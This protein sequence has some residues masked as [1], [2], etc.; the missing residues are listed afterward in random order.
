LHTKIIISIAGTSAKDLITCI[1]KISTEFSPTAFELNLSCPNV[2]HNKNNSKLI[3]Q[4]PKQTAKIIKKIKKSTKNKIIAKLSPAVTDITE[5]ALAAEQAGADAVS[6]VNTYPGMAVNYKTGKPILGNISGG[7]S[8]PA[9]KPLA[10]KAVYDTAKKINIP[11]IGIGGISSATDVLEFIACG[12]KAVQIGTANL[13]DPCAY[14]NVL[15]EYNKIIKS[16]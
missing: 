10:L 4:D 9:I 13:V 11:I 8:G 12:A 5:I 2:K 15:A 14:N 6:L 3:S 7:L 1:E 16:A